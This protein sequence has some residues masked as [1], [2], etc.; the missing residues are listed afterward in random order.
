MKNDEYTKEEL[1]SIL[2]DLQ[3]WM[4]TSVL[5]DNE[6]NHNLIEKTERMIAKLEEKEE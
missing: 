1:A 4:A 5:S 3:F 6:F 2:Q